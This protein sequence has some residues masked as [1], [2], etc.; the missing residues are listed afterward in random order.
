MTLDSNTSNGFIGVSFVLRSTRCRAARRDAR[1][2]EF[3]GSAAEEGAGKP[4]LDR[5]LECFERRHGRLSRSR[6]RTSVIRPV[7]AAAAA[8]S[9]D[10]RNVRPPRPWRPSKLRLLVLTA[11][12]P[13]SGA[14]PFLAMHIEAPGPP[15]PAPAPPT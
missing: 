10:A 8:V 6:A 5:R 4:P 7:T 12:W 14:A 2:G 15:P 1:R 13:G 3:R 11:Y 9:G